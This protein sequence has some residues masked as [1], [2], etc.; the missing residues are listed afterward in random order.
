[1]G[2]DIQCIGVTRPAATKEPILPDNRYSML[3]GPDGNLGAV[4]PSD[5]PG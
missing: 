1:M 3:N 5:L 2:R 4:R